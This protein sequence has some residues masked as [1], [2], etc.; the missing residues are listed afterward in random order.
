MKGKVVKGSDFPSDDDRPAPASS[1]KKVIKREVHSAREEGKQ[2]LGAAD[3]E[4][5]R[6][7]DEAK[8]EADRIRKKAESDGYEE[9]LGRLNDQALEFQQQ[10]EKLIDASRSDILKLAVRIAGKILGREVETNEKALGDIVVKAMRGIAHEK[11]IQIRV[12]PGDLDK[13]RK[14]HD[15]LIDEVGSGKEVELREDKNVSPG[16]CIVE[17]DLG[18]I[19]AQLETQLR[20]LERALLDRKKG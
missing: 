7:V 3:D 14:Q 9:G 15:R 17:T 16:G 4:A 10:R 2:I 6:I 11:R 12:N 18:I 5:R 8:A 19:D 1:G 20:V 13:I